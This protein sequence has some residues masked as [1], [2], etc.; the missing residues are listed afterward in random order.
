MVTFYSAVAAGTDDRP[1]PFRYLQNAIF[2]IRDGYLHVE[3][4]KTGTRI[5]ILWLCVAIN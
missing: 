3:Q 1:A 4:Q 2:G 5:A